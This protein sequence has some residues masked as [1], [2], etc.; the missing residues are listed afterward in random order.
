MDT[1]VILI[2]ENQAKDSKGEYISTPTRREVFARKTSVS[3]AEFFQAGQV[4]LS[5]DYRFLV[6]HGDYKGESVLEY[7]KKR[8]AIYR[9][10]HDGDYIELYCQ[11]E[12]GVS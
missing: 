11:R 5:P 8:Y 7:D 3:A 4:G 9:T 2:G 12:A 10:Y 6:F 1:T